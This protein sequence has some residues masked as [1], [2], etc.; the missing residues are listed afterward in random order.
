M[1]ECRS[2]LLD[3]KIARFKPMNFSFLFRL[4]TL[5]YETSHS[6][7]HK[8]ITHIDVAAID[9]NS[10]LGIF[11]QSRNHFYVIVDWAIASYGITLKTLKYYHSYHSHPLSFQD[12]TVYHNVWSNILPNNFYC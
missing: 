2:H 1:R 12:C 11:E 4:L 3:S 6:T 8:F 5:I 9:I 7:P 10:I